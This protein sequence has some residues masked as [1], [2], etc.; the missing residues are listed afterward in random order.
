MSTATQVISGTHYE[1]LMEGVD[2]ETR[3]I[4]ENCLVFF[5]NDADTSATEEKARS[6]KL[7]TAY[8]TL[9]DFLVSNRL[10]ELN[11]HQAAFLCTGAIA[12]SILV[13]STSPKTITLLPSQ[14]YLKL[15]DN[16][17]KPASSNAAFSV[18]SVLDKYTAI[19]KGELLALTLGDDRKKD[20][21]NSPQDQKRAKEE[22]K[23]RMDQLKS[24]IAM[25]ISQIDI[26]YP[27]MIGSLNENSLK[28]A[29]VGLEMMKKVSAA[30][31]RGEAAT[32]QEKA[33]IKAFEGKIGKRPLP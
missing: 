30:W 5:A 15:I 24:E 31:A 27:K 29:K 28:N 18:F 19:A 25:S 26:Y 23:R 3:T 4:V 6:D 32:P 10:N 14:L 8:N 16:F 33:L 22:W 20:L 11:T 2:A 21:R 13:Q 1:K 17:S 9:V 12:D 7:R